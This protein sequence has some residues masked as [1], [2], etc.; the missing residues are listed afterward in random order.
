V[1]IAI[2]DSLNSFMLERKGLHVAV[3]V[4]VHS[5][6]YSETELGAS[7]EALAFHSHA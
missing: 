3:F 6:E 7:G 4:P 5:A 2:A 1:V